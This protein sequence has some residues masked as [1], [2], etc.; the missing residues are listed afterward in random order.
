MTKQDY[1]DIAAI[2]LRNTRPNGTLNSTFTLELG[3]YYASRNVRF[4]MAKWTLDCGYG[5]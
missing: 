5:I 4:D 3:V 1:K 2:I